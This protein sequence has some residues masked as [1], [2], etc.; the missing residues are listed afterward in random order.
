[1]WLPRVTEAKV[2]TVDMQLEESIG[3]RPSILSRVLLNQNQN[4]LT[5]LEMAGHYVQSMND[6]SVL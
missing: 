5:E 3:Y 6:T 1:M 4:T 2:L